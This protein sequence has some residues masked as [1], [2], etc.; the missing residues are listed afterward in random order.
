MILCAATIYIYIYI[1]FNV[2]RTQA[3]A[4]SQAHLLLLYPSL[5]PTSQESSMHLCDHS[6]FY[7][8]IHHSI[9]SRQHFAHIWTNGVGLPWESI[10]ERRS[11]QALKE[12]RRLCEK[13]Y[14]WRGP[15]AGPSKPW[16]AH[17]SVH[18]IQIPGT[19]SRKNCSLPSSVQFMLLTS[20]TS[21]TINFSGEDC[22]CVL[23][24]LFTNISPFHLL[25]KIF[26]GHVACGIPDQGLN[27]CPCM[28]S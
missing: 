8:I 13:E 3:W 18:G 10:E 24:V 16:N 20:V 2:H 14:C 25:F 17:S 9:T 4:W 22:S 23:V 19:N 28:T 27:L 26:I 11:A 7:C 21:V 12:N 1:F 6:S 15:R 5:Y